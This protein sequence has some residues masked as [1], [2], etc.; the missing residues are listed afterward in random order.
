MLGYRKYTGKI[1]ILGLQSLNAHVTKNDN[2]CCDVEA[3]KKL[4]DEAISNLLNQ[5]EEL[6]GKAGEISRLVNFFKKISLFRG[7]RKNM[8]ISG[9]NSACAWLTPLTAIHKFSVLSTHSHD[10]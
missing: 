9:R 2:Q 10:I 8:V 5:A 3:A 4:I 1:L 7:L 6:P